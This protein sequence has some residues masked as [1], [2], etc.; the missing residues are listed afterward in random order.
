M[1][2]LVSD[3]HLTDTPERS[4]FDVASFERTIDSLLREPA[5]Q[6]ASE[7]RL[8]LL[9]DVLEMLKSTAWLD[10]DV[11]PWEAPDARHV[12]TVRAIVDRIVAANSD[13]FAVLRTLREKHPRLALT[14]VIGNH[15]RP[16]N[17]AM[18]TGSRT[19]VRQ[20]LG[21]E[22]G[23]ALFPEA[24]DDP[25][26][27]LLAQHGHH[28]D[29]SNRYSGKSI[30]I[31]DAVVIDVLT[32]LPIVFGRYLDVDPEDPLL[33]FVHEIDNVIPQTPFQMAKWLADNIT[34]LPWSAR[35]HL[36]AALGEIAEDL[37]ERVARYET[38][39]AIGTWWVA[40][41]K[42]VALVVGP[43]KSALKL[44]RGGSAPPALARNV[45]FD[46]EESRRLHGV[47]YRYVVYGHTHIPDLRSVSTGAGLT[48]YLNS[49]TWRRLHR[50]VDSAIDPAS[51][52]YA[53]ATA[54]SLIIVRHEREQNGGQPGYE[55]R[56]SYHD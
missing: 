3:L 40:A 49:G 15:D 56:Q 13:V 19:V 45:A 10:R 54:H 34:A 51:R 38:E 47:S 5:S 20:Q 55:L 18:G 39:S 4:T 28:W 14:Y 22:G 29:K 43:V 35:A 23:D 31:G 9:G 7:I 24:Y 6:A 50:V 41:L 26:H 33:G 25:D 21:I 42:H 53:T 8:V 1:V 30:A 48:Y 46:V 16:L 44:P 27:S 37:M 36:D 52:G 12:A 32:R 17:T 11:R 2:I